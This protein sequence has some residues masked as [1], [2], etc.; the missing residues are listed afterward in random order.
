VAMS[1][2]YSLIR[3]AIPGFEDQKEIKNSGGAN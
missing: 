1:E 2:E 3:F